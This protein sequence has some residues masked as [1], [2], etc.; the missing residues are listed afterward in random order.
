MSAETACWKNYYYGGVHVPMFK[1]H[2]KNYLGIISGS[3]SFQGWGSFRGLY[4]TLIL[5]VWCFTFS[6]SFK[7]SLVWDFFLL[8]STITKVIIFSWFLFSSCCSC[9]SWLVDL[10]ELLTNLTSQTNVLFQ[11]FKITTC[12]LVLLL[13]DALDVIFFGRSL[14]IRH[15]K[16]L[17]HAMFIT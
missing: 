12:N 2:S 7:T 14:L 10:P 3:G 1:R 6:A 13:N 9:T 16:K 4:S 8:F 11:N 5:T 17:N 15:V